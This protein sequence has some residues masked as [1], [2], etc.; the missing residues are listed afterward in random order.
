MSGP[1]SMPVTTCRIVRPA[2]EDRR[3]SG[4]VSYARYWSV[5]SVSPAVT[6]TV[7]ARSAVSAGG[8]RT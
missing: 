4:R 8:E 1:T 3:S 6:G 2:S 7:T 5:N